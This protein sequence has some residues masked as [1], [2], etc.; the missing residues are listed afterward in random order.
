MPWV[1]MALCVVELAELTAYHGPRKA[2]SKFVRGALPAGGNGLGAVAKGAAGANQTSGALGLG[3]VAA[4]AVTS[5]F[6]FLS[7]V[8]PIAGG[9]VAD[10]KWG[11]EFCRACCLHEYH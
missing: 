6:T 7:Y 2:F 4:S 11:R 8:I 3:S 10:T 5:T 1:E 9:I